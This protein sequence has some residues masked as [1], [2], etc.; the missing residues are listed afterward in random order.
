MLR[1]E[2]LFA[3][4]YDEADPDAGA[5]LPGGEDPAAGNTDPVDSAGGQDGGQEYTWGDNWRKE[6][7]GEDEKELKI[8]ERYAS[9]KDIYHKARELEK[10]L[11]SGELVA[12]SEFPVNGTDEE[13][14]EWR[15]S[16]GLPKT[17]DDYDL[18][19]EDGITF[20]E[21]DQA[22]IDQ[23][24]QVAINTN[25]SN[26]QLKD[27]LRWYNEFQEQQVEAMEAKDKEDRDTF[28][29]EYKKEW[30][31]DYDANINLINHML[32]GAP[33]GVKD[34]ILNGRQPDG[35]A[36]GNDPEIMAW[37][38]STARE[39]NPAGTLTPAGGGET[40]TGI[41]DEISKIEN[42]MKTDRKKYNEDQ[43]MQQRLRD[44]YSAREK[45]NRRAG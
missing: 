44:L 22:I 6:M 43:A 27:T 34:K 13:K 23:F 26:E 30:G 35:T 42:V 2:R 12:K 4:K 1:H 32:D 39:M 11:S 15:E 38:A 9:P 40:I 21:E 41:Q 25:M 31:A 5:D 24:K 45:L 28:I 3:R 36:F 29:Q 33:D 20:G 37:L 10:K 19:F 8:L 17:A 18:N 7:A 14:A 16:Q